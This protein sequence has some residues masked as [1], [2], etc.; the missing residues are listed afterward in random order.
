MAAEIGTGVALW[1]GLN[2]AFVAWR[3]YLTRPEGDRN[4]VYAAGVEAGQAGSALSA[5]SLARRFRRSR[6]RLLPASSAAASKA[7]RASW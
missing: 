2:L 5:A 3:L 7:A 4:T 1:V 6:S